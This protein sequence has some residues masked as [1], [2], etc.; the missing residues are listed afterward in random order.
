MA[1]TVD[2]STYDYATGKYV[3]ETLT[4]GVGVTLRVYRDTVRV[5]SDEW[6]ECIAA[7]YWNEEKGRVYSVPFVKDAKVD[8]TPE[9]MAKVREYFYK[10]NLE[11]VT[12]DAEKEVRRITKGS[13]VKVTSGRTGKGTEG[14]VAVII[15]RPYGM[16]Y[17]SSLEKK[18]AIPTSDVMI[19]VPARNGK[20]YKNYRD[21]VWVWARNCELVEV[22]AIDLESVKE[23][24]E[25]KVSS[26]MRRFG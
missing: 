14:I 16:G 20:V 15:E 10:S 5:M 21:V 23:C 26:I 13:K 18:I 7:E 19:D 4:E 2:R 17:R 25:E 12:A 11:E 3:T 8:A 6:T 22:P 1:F 24:A 9:V